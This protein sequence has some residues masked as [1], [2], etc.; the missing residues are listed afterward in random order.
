MDMYFT[1]EGDIRISPDG[2]IALTD[3][4]GRET[5][6]QAYIRIM[7]EPGDYTL[8]PQLGAEMSRLYGMPQSQQTGNYGAE[9]IYQALNRESAFVGKQ[10][11][12]RPIPTGPQ[13]I[14]FDV[15]VGEDN[16]NIEQ[17][18][19]IEQDLGVV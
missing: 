1:H 7:T 15:F 8:Y 2:D 18:L 6:Q 12:V 16:R 9:L 5:A 19:S 17:I 13:T 3:S 10:I 14:R 11:T 4:F